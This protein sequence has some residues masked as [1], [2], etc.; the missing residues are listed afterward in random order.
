MSKMPAK[1]KLKQIRC[2]ALSRHKDFNLTEEY[3]KNILDQKTCAYSGEAFGKDSPNKMT[4]ERV[5]NDLGYVLGNVVP[6][7]NKYNSRRGSLTLSQLMFAG[8]LVEEESME[9]DRPETLSPKL[10]K[11]YKTIES[12]KANKLSREKKCQIL[13]TKQFK[14]SLNEK[15]LEEFKSLKRKIEN[16]I[17][18]IEKQTAAANQTIKM[19]KSDLRANVKTLNNAASEYGIIASGLLKIMHAS[20]ENKAR[21]Y[22]GLPMLSEESCS[23]DTLSTTETKKDLSSQSTTIMTRI[24]FLCHK[25]VNWLKFGSKNTK[26]N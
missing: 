15:E 8:G 14:K 19:L 22:Q 1:R 4:F 21:L 20:P 23:T 3:V 13:L 12:L 11:I 17:I 6:V 2:S 5:D 10:A 7:K 16:A 24:S 18:E 25:I 9:L 26:T